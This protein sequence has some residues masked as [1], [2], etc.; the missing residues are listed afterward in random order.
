[1]NDT[2]GMQICHACSHIA[3]N[4]QTMR[5]RLQDSGI[6]WLKPTITLAPPVAGRQCC[7]QGPTR[8]QLHD[9]AERII[10]HTQ[11]RNDVWMAKANQ[12]LYLPEAIAS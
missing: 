12:Q 5:P 4:A 7:K 6:V 11:K 9:D 2:S 1:M 8:H 3:S 10:R